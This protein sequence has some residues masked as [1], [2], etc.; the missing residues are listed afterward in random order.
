MIVLGIE[1]SCDETSTAIV[2]DKREILSNE[3]LS[4]IDVHQLY[5]GVVPEIA[6][7]RH[8]DVLE[9]LVT[10]SLKNTGL[11]F[12]DIDGIAA[13]SGP[14]LIG[15]L[16]VG[17]MMAK[18]IALAKNKPFLATNHLEGHSLTV[19][20]TDGI[21]FPYLLLLVSGGHCQILNIKDYGQYEVY[22]QTMDDA[23][24]EAFDKV[25]KMLDLPYP[26]GPSVEKE[27][28]KG[29]TSA[30]QFPRSMKGKK[31]CDFSFSGL[32]TAVLYQI[33]KMKDLSALDKQNIAASFQNCV[34]DILVDRC[35]R[36]MEKFKIEM[37]APH[38][39][40]ISGGV[41]ANQF[42][43]QK[44]KNLCDSEGFQFFA[45]PQKLCTDNAAMI[46]WA[47][48]EKLLRNSQDTLSF[49]P[50]PRW[51]LNEIST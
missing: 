51:P 37:N 31:H 40:V 8:M 19:R 43:G 24:G 11:T 49:K 28:L 15:G 4:Q 45:P 3:I 18:G 12:D 23:V 6:A 7:R 29:S 41:A 10:T 27:A 14:G 42:I 13:T 9:K 48:M 30:F 1:S 32:K 50:R 33:Q 36:A 39:F 17:V 35:Q 34:A 21:E 46:A 22:G 25:A 2:N 16:I 47:G 44:L 5:G 38:Q 20:L 26:G